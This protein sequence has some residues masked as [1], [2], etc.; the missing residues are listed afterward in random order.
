MKLNDN[1]NLIFDPTENTFLFNV[2]MKFFKKKKRKIN[3]KIK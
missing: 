3:L 1:V 2:L